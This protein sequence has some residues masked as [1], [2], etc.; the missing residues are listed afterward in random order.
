MSAYETLK[1]YFYQKIYVLF[2]SLLCSHFE[3]TYGYL[4]SFFMIRQT[5]KQQE[6][7]TIN[8]SSLLALEWGQQ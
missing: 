7:V 2:P 8:S 6:N 3:G 5:V 1:Y 4:R